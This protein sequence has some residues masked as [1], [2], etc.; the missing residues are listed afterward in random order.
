M[1]WLGV[2]QLGVYQ[3]IEVTQRPR[4]HLSG[5]SV[6]LEC[7]VASVGVNCWELRG[8]PSTYPWTFHRAQ[9]FLRIAAKFLEGAAPEWPFSEAK[10]EAARLLTVL[11][12]KT[13]RVTSATFYRS[14][15]SWRPR[16]GR[17]MRLQ[18]LRGKRQDHMAEEHIWWNIWWRPSLENRIC[19][20]GYIYSCSTC[21]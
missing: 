17:V 16:S 4:L 7:H 6:E 21:Q 3:A 14:S 18:F 1:D 15:Q 11:S 2:D 8:L 13:Q 5:G 19:Q 9:S 20:T 12:Q 10:V